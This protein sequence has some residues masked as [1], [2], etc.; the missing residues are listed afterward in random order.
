LPPG[1]FRGFAPHSRFMIWL[2]AKTWN[3]M[4]RWPMSAI[5]RK[6]INRADAITLP[7]YTFSANRVYR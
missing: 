4:G 1:G 2:R 5:M 7:D 3:M 6:M